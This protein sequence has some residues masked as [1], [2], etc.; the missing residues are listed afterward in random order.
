MEIIGLFV[1]WF[2]FWFLVY[3]FLAILF[4][5]YASK[6]RRSGVGWF[7]LS[8][9]VSPIITLIFLFILGPSHSSLKKCPRC[10]EE[11]K[12]E[13]MVCRFCNYEFPQSNQFPKSDKKA[14]NVASTPISRVIAILIALSAFGFMVFIIYL[15]KK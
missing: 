15:F 2:V 3:L 7:F 11:V 6:K 9:L 8:L 14:G 4:G 10:A 5:V 13:A 12:I 1:G